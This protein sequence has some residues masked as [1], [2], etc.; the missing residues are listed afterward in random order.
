M[1]FISPLQIPMGVELGIG[2][3]VLSTGRLNPR[4]HLGPPDPSKDKPVVL[5]GK[6]GQS[7]KG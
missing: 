7:F 5:F 6:L 2:D 1:N 3:P 4:Q